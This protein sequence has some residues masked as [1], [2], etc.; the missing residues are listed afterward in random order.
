LLPVLGDVV[1]AAAPWN[2]DLV[3]R[4]AGERVVLHI[5]VDRVDFNVSKAAVVDLSHRCP[6]K[7]EATAETWLA[8]LTRALGRLAEVTIGSVVHVGLAGIAALPGVLGDAISTAAGRQTGA[9]SAA[10]GHRVAS[11]VAG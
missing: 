2:A 4:G 3:G 5:A 1:S 6:A 9:S 10:L 8:R 11:R 7:L